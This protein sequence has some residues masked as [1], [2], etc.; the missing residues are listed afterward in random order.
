MTF[1]TGVDKEGKILARKITLIQDCG[2]YNDLG[3]GVLRYA[4]LMGAGPY[5]IKNVWI[6]GYLV[7]TNKNVGTVMRGVG[8]PQVNFAGE[9]Q[10]DIIA[11][12][13]KMD[14]F[15]IRLKNILR[16][17]DITPNGQKI[18]NAGIEKCLKELRKKAHYDKYI[19]KPRRKH[20]GLGLSAMIYDCSAAGGKDYSSAI[21]KFNEDGSVI[22][23]T[24]IPDAGQGARTALSQIAAEE[25]GMKYED[26]WT[27]K[28]DTAY[29]PLDKLGFA[30]SRVS[31]M[32]GH[33]VR[34]AACEAK[35]Q[36]ID[37]IS[38]KEKIPREA[39]LFKKGWV[40]INEKKKRQIK[41]IV[42]QMIGKEGKTILGEGSHNTLSV[43]MDKKNGLSNTVE[44][45]LFG[46]ALAEVEV[47][48]NTGIVNV[49][50]IWQSH[51]IGKAI[52]PTNLEGQVEGGVVQALGFALCEKLIHD[53]YGKVM[54]PNFLDYKIFTALDMPKVHSIIVEIP[55]PKGPFDIKGIGE[56]TAIPGA[57]A[58]AN[59]VKD[60]EDID[61]N[62]LPMTPE[63]IYG[64]LKLR[65]I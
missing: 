62:Q 27:S 22:V 49:L 39:I 58:I 48:P 12:K 56:N 4:T 11:K 52:N 45:Y 46:A 21:V 63:Y 60:A 32:A 57:A 25:L 38:I 42:K 51:D 2:A 13:L 55:E 28:G 9:Q 40:Y 31:Y 7:Y 29:S 26:V 14:P 8:V 37:Y 36:I 15:D 17:G 19:K 64:Q 43:K 5:S 1:K 50:N 30:G 18:F 61:I 34:N 24:G 35:N 41:G 54:N 44:L 20:V 6:D 47:D 23:L 53:K 10:I 65:K 59:A 3:E 16:D 33:A